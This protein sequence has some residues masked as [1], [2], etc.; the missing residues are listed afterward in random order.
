M[1]T[2]KKNEDIDYESDEYFDGHNEVDEPD[3]YYC[4]CC[5]ESQANHSSSCTNC[6]MYNTL[7]EG[8]F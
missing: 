1:N 7:E 3:Y 2:E 6:G 8:Y 5:N 4:S